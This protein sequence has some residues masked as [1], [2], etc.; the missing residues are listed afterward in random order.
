MYVL[1]ISSVNGVGGSVDV[2]DD[3][4]NGASDGDGGSVVNVVNVVDDAATGAADADGD[5]GG[6]GVKSLILL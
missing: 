3:A 6:G 5:A 2:V 4:S 1:K